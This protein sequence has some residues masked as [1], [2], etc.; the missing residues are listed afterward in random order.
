M[1]SSDFEFSGRFGI[2]LGK[3]GDVNY[4]GYSDIAVSAPFEN[5]GVVYIFLGGPNGLSKK[6]SQVL[7]APKV[8]IHKYG[9]AMFGHGISRGVDID[10]NGHNDI[11]IGAPNSEIVYVYKSYPVI[12]VISSISSTKNE[13]TMEDNG[14][15]INV[16]LYYESRTNVEQEHDL[17]LQLGVDMQHNRASFSP[18][19][20]KKVINITKKINNQPHCWEYDVYVKSSLAD[21]FK[22][23]NIEVKYDLISKVPQD[24]S[25]FCE[26][27][28][29]IDPNDP[30]VINYKV[31]FS[32]GCAGERCISDLVVKGTLVNIR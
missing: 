6:P 7:K 1:I 28:V 30:K 18:K 31:A 11:A 27:C 9:T 25:E 8:D 13:L 3:I 12:K 4:D 15:Q 19:E 21:I 32:T 26:N 17:S 20:P 24:V 2:S 23:I 5:D 29:T 14:F 16:C 10:N 22:P